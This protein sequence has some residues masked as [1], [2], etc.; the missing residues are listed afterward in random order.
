MLLNLL[1]LSLHR[2]RRYD[3]QE[4]IVNQM[5]YSM[6]IFNQLKQLTIE[7]R[8]YQDKYQ[9]LINELRLL[10]NTA[11]NQEDFLSM[12]IANENFINDEISSCK[13]TSRQSIKAHFRWC[14]SMENN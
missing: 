3:E 13:K 10:K 8:F 12:I 14:I 9:S 7:Y 11:M 1:P 4:M 5:N 6:M 2:K